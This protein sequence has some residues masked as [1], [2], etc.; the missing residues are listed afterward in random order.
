MFKVQRKVVD[1]EES[2]GKYTSSKFYTFVSQ[3]AVGKGQSIIKVAMTLVIFI[4]A[5]IEMQTNASVTEWVQVEQMSREPSSRWG[6]CIP[7][8]P[9]TSPV[10]STSTPPALVRVWDTRTRP[11]WETWQ[12]GANRSVPPT[13]PPPIESPAVGSGVHCAGWCS[14]LCAGVV[15]S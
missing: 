15:Q 11:V 6:W 9:S 14:A 10:P 13:A 4:G 7:F 8:N 5:S 12:P 1:R 2:L 3:L